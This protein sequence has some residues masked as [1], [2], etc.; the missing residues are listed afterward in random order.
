M[1]TSDAPIIVEQ[2]FNASVESVWKSLTDTEEMHNGILIISRHL[3]LRLDL[4]LNSMLQA[5]RET[6]CINGM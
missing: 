2:I 6:F 4:R 5:E 1:K 3:N